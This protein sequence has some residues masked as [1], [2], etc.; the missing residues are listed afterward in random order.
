M[1][2]IVRYSVAV[3][4][5]IVVVLSIASCKKDNN[6]NYK[7]TCISFSMDTLVLFGGEE[8]TVTVQNN[9]KDTWIAT[10]DNHIKEVYFTEYPTDLEPGEQCTFSVVCYR[11]YGDMEVHRDKLVF[12]SS[13]GYVELPYVSFPYRVENPCFVSKKL[14]FPQGVSNFKFPIDNSGSTSISYS[15]TSSSGKAELSSSSGRIQRYGRAEI[16]VKVNDPSYWQGNNSVELY[17]TSGN[18]VDTIC[19]A[20]EKK[21]ILEGEDLKAAYSR[22]A[23]RL[24]IL[25]ESSLMV[26]NTTNRTFD[27]I[28]LPSYP[29]NFTLSPDGSKAIVR[30]ENGF[31]YVNL[32][33]LYIIDEFEFDGINSYDIYYLIL[34]SDGW[35]YLWYDG[36]L[37]NSDL[38][39]DSHKTNLVAEYLDPSLLHPSGNYLYSFG[40]GF[41]NKYA[42]HHD[43]LEFIEEFELENNEDYIL[44]F[45]PQGDKLFT[46]FG[47]AYQVSDMPNDN[48]EIIGK[49]E[50]GFDEEDYPSQYLHS[51]SCVSYNEV[52][53]RLYMVENTQ[54]EQKHKFPCVYVS[55]LDD[56]QPVENIYTEP[57]LSMDASGLVSMKWNYVP[58]Y[59]F[60]NAEGNTLYVVSA[61]N[62]L[63]GF[64]I[65]WIFES[66][67]L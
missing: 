20:M 28:K 9:G 63:Y 26:Y 1:K 62:F 51:F 52:N 41:T 55:N 34:M 11:T 40:Y 7:A 14:Y 8:V 27:V 5:F 65:Q 44:D 57:I 60:V 13:L 4:A 67:A 35:A 36:N 45:S 43:E 22:T 42:F 32:D 29:Y 38:N 49:I 6:Y 33:N 58:M 16:D 37:Y 12:T 50:V 46:Y 56:L 48:L 61:K 15:I 18:H 30:C 31:A 66:I 3:V 17:V 39:D 23:D 24:V 53:H 19:V 47:S 64:E 10:L 59:A 21:Q 54:G 25:S 2:H